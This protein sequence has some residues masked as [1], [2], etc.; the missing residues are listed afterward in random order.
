M[1]FTNRYHRR[2]ITTTSLAEYS[3]L[4]RWTD[5]SVPDIYLFLSISMLMTRNS[6]LTIEEHWS[7]DPLLSAPIFGKLMSRNRYGMILGML[8]FQDI[9]E[10]ES[11]SDS[12]LIKID[13]MIQHARRIFKETLNP[14]SNLCIDES[15]VPFK[16]RLVLKQ[17]LPRKRNRFGIKLFVLCDFHTGCIVDFIVYCGATTDIADTPELGISGSV[18][19]KL[20][21]DYFHC[22][23]RLYVDN[24]YSSPL[25]FRYL[26]AKQ[27]YA[28]GTVRVS[29]RGMPKFNKIK[30]GEIDVHHC[31]SLMALKWKDKNDVT[32]LS[33]MHDSKIVKSDKIDYTTGLSKMKPECVVDYSKHMGSVDR[34]DM[35]MSSLT[36]MR[37]TIKWH[38]KLGLHIFDMHMLNS[39][40]I[41]NQVK[42]TKLNL[43]TFQLNVVRQC[44][45]KYKAYIPL[46]LPQTSRTNAI[47]DALRLLPAGAAKH[48]PKYIPNRK[49]QRCKVCSNNKK[50]SNTRFYQY[51]M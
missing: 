17:Y 31:D 45:E 3:R 1:K 49:S 2:L 15:I 6:H 12:R 19:V 43:A 26:K 4:H 14:Y 32:L 40:F 9:N 48:M 29:R 39:F 33:T 41:H 36:I 42:L 23:R 28:C 24:W 16:G 11:T 27:T 50:R 10:S 51:A 37:K 18:V 44:I 25:L 5:V 7:T 47:K 35:M 21:E 46:I 22:N 20:L 30:K 8:C 38:K 34:T 13:F